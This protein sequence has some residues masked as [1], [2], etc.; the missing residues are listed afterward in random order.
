MFDNLSD[1][2]ALT[3]K[4]LKG[5]GKLS[6]SNIS[7]ALREV[8]LALLEADVNYKVA[9]EFIAKIKDRAVGQEV[10]KSLTPAQ[11]VIKIVRDELCALMGGEA[12]PLNLGGKAPH[13]FMMVGL[14]GSGKTTTSG[15]LAL[16]LKKQGRN[17]YLVPADTQR[18]AAIEQL[19]K[20]GAQIQVPVFDSNPAQDPV[21]ICVQSLS[22]AS[23][24]GCD[25]IILD[26]AGRLHVDHELMAQLERIQS[27]LR[28]QE[29]LL[30]ADAMTGQDAV[31]VSQAFHEQLGL[32]GVVLTKVEGDARGGAALSIRAVSQVPIKLVGV[33]E[34]LDAIEAFHPDRLAGRILG[35]GDM[36]T[37]VEKAGEAFEAE[38]AEALAKKMATDNFTLDDFKDQLQQLK[39]MGSLDGLLSMLPGA[40]KLKGMKN[41]QPDEK[42]L[43]RTEAIIN[44][45]T[46]GERGNHQ[47]INS[48]RRKRIARGSGTS[49]SEVNR[50][51]KNF[52]QARKMMKGM[53]KMGG[54]KKQLARLMGAMR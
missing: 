21:D 6:E 2:L 51:L 22:G 28:P 17:P 31:N 39:K 49:V 45:M 12:E 9:K 52:T 34:K 25:V 26:T 42:E 44:S 13:V 16:M 50:L 11:Q 37:L 15:K 19:K 43:K 35:M 38:K 5:H 10:M 33:G 30:V 23:R 3:F 1:R 24:A 27:R 47:I 32:T 4:R 53:A 46:P 8:R 40:G 18:P 14:Q 7:E 29:V 54:K 48:S 20:L 41:L 36:L